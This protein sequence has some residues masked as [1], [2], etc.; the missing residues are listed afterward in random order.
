MPVYGQF[1]YTPTPYPGAP[2][3]QSAT[4]P[5]GQAGLTATQSRRKYD[6]ATGQ[7]SYDT[8]YGLGLEGEL[9]TR[10]K[11]NRA[12]EARRLASLQALGG[13]GGAGLPRESRT[14]GPGFDREQAARSAAFA[15][16]KD[17]AGTA[18]R[19]AL[20]SLQD[21][22][23]DKGLGAGSTFEAGQAG[24]ILGGAGGSLGELAREQAILDAEQAG[25]AADLEFT[26]GITQRG[27]DLQRQQAIMGLLN[28]L[29][30]VY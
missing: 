21:L 9:A 29:G 25:R 2:S 20:T 18:A 11:Y 6:P 3:G 4:A 26:G 30:V 7:T 22:V 27:Q 14:S 17:Q 16:A 10:D 1:G 19:S 24:R 8:E 23:T 12:A 13:A 28:S 15:R 5:S